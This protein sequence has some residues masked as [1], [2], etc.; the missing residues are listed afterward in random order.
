MPTKVRATAI[1]NTASGRPLAPGDEVSLPDTE[2]TRLI[3]TGR[4]V[5]LATRKPASKKETADAS[6]G[7]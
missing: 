4:A 1:C 6:S 7:K 3:E 2:A 5:A